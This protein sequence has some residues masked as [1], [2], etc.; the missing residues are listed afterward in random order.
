MQGRGIYFTFQDFGERDRDKE[1][2]KVGRGFLLW[3]VMW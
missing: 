1:G 2:R 3:R